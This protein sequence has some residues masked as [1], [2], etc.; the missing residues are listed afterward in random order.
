MDAAKNITYQTANTPNKKLFTPNDK[1]QYTLYGSQPYVLSG[2]W[3]SNFTPSGTNMILDHS[4][5]N[6]LAY[7]ISNHDKYAS[8]TN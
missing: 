6:I 1:T 2:G 4:M 5:D 3:P 8:C 7:N